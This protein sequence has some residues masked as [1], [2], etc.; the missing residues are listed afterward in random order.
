MIPLQLYSPVTL[1]EQNRGVTIPPPK[2]TSSPGEQR[3]LLQSRFAELGCSSLCRRFS[4]LT[5]FFALSGFRLRL[6]QQQRLPPAASHPGCLQPERC[7][8]PLRQSATR[9]RCAC[10]AA[11][12]P[13]RCRSR[14]QA[15]LSPCR[16]S[17]LVCFALSPVSG[18]QMEL[19]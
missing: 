10:T 2:K 19:G 11:A 14:L 4:F 12:W 7:L 6:P 16:L 18:D 9:R 3:Q 1:G 8:E 15:Q 17:V 5:S 13:Q